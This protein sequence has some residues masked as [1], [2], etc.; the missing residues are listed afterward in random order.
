MSSTG[1][2][3]GNGRM[4]SPA[5]GVPPGTHIDGDRNF[6][7]FQADWTLGCCWAGWLRRGESL[8]MG[9]KALAAREPEARASLP[10][11]KA[12]VAHC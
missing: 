12:G 3:N 10:T 7:A 6:D 9:M 4:T 11:R 2:G 5:F 1:T 8:K